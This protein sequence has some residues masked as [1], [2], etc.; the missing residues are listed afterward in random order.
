MALPGTKSPPCCFPK[1]ADGESQLG[2][3]CK[4]IKYE[5]LRFDGGILDIGTAPT[6]RVYTKDYRKIGR[7]VDDTD[8]VT[9]ALG[10]PLRA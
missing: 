3:G 5:N 9:E 10:N 6:S 8:T 1:A 2:D 7:D 4:Q